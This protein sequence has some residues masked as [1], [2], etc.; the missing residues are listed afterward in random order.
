MQIIRPINCIFIILYSITKS[1]L[2]KKPPNRRLVIIFYVDDVVEVAGDDVIHDGRRA[3]P[4]VRELLC[5]DLRGGSLEGVE[6][7]YDVYV[8]AVAC[9]VLPQIQA[10]LHP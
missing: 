5:D 3:L 7:A 8:E 10:Y 2:L 9:G 4:L 6:V 1:N